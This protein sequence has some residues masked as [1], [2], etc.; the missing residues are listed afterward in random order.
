VVDPHDGKYHVIIEGFNPEAL[1]HVVN[2]IHVNIGSLP[3]Y[4]TLEQLAHIA[5]LVEYYDM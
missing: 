2:I 3:R 5:V 4:L 1:E